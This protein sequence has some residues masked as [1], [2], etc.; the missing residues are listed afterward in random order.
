MHRGKPG[1]WLFAG[2]LLTSAAQLLSQQPR[3]TKELTQPS[4]PQLEMN[5]SSESPDEA[6]QRNQRFW[7]VRGV[8]PGQNP[9][10][11]RLS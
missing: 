3:Q 7:H 5:E 6:E 8:V 2:I 1:K 10:L 11:A 4:R 9:A